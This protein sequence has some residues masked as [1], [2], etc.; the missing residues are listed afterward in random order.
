MCIRDS[1]RRQY[2]AET[3]EILSK[4]AK[5]AIDTGLNVI[6]CVGE[7]LQQRESNQ[8]EAVV[9]RQIEALGS[10]VSKSQWG[11]LV[12]A[13]EP[14]WAIGTGKTATAQ[15][16]Q[17]VH[18]AIRGLISKNVDAN[19]A[20]ALRVIYGGSVTD[21]NSAELIAER[22]IDGFLVGGASLKPGFKT[23]V[24]SCNNARK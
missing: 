13:Y 1:E 5:L 12:I 20:Q 15:Q 21:T 9:R 16:A 10:Q 18:A 23:I 2:Y 11:N 19:V 24:D 7:S 8:T 17:E 6:Y 22:D 3:D 14:I 4:K